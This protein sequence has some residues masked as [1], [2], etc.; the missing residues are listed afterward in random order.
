MPFLMPSQP[1]MPPLPPMPE[2][3]KDEKAEKKAVEK[4]RRGIM[5][6]KGRASLLLTDP[7]GM[8]AAPVRVKTALGE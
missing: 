7:L 6:A 5:E 4:M 3:P 2:I 1:D 8:S